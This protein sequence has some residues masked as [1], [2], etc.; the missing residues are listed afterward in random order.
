MRKRPV[1][2]RAFHLSNDKKMLLE[3]DE[4]T[5]L[6]IES[7]DCFGCEYASIA[8]LQTYKGT[9]SFSGHKSNKVIFLAAEVESPS[10]SVFALSSLFYETL[11]LTF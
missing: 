10:F 6:Q 9:A 5:S 11:F 8:L 2:W 7:F 1:V 3:F 4:E